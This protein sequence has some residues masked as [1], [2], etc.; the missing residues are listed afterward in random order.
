MLAVTLAILAAAPPV[1]SISPLVRGLG[2]RSPEE[3]DLAQRKLQ[4]LGPEALPRLA[5]EL[6]SPDPEVRRRLLRVISALEVE[7]DLRPTR[8]TLA[9]SG[10]PLRE[11]L[12]RLQKELKCEL[13]LESPDQEVLNHRVTATFRDAA[14]WDV[15]DEV[16]RQA[17]LRTL[18]FC[19]LDQPQLRLG[20]GKWPRPFEARQGAFRLALT[21]LALHRELDFEGD[22]PPGPGVLEVQLTLQA[23]PRFR[24]LQVGDPEIE[25]A[26]DG[27]GKDLVISRDGGGQS[28]RL[29]PISGK[30]SDLPGEVAAIALLAH[31]TSG[32]TRLQ[33]LKGAVLATVFIARKTIVVMDRISTG[34]KFVLGGTSYEVKSRKSLPGAGLELRVA[35]SAGPA[36]LVEQD[37]VLWGPES[38][39]FTDRDGR[40]CRHTVELLEGTEGV[41][42]T[43]SGG[44]NGVTR[45]S[46]VKMLHDALLTREIRIPFEFRNVP[47]P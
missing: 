41:R 28:N 18:S 27:K 8:V 4:A 45:T 14:F 31:P 21:R 46:P 11:V 9:F 19:N 6:A 26:L 16:C 34:A 23:D 13:V 5:R 10:E 17:S 20:P 25:A 30:P 42:L 12:A 33:R 7:K 43:I 47:L 15:M 24:I 29:N 22:G 36:A 3:R 38:V 40:A 39:R 35:P 1:D 32:A 2:A 44:R 37:S